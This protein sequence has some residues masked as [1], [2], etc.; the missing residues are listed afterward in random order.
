M[1]KYIRLILLSSFRPLLRL[2]GI[3]LPLP[4][5]QLPLLE[6]LLRPLDLPLGALLVLGH[7]VPSLL[8]GGVAG[9]KPLEPS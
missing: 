2:L 3:L 9:G 6:H 5:L 8:H 7:G 1:P 4:L